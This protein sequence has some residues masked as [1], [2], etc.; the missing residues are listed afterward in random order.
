[1][2]WGGI[3]FSSLKGLDGDLL[4]VILFRCL[5]GV[6]IST[7]EFLLSSQELCSP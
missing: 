5:L 7:I 1:M 2:E 6:W 3:R 4:D